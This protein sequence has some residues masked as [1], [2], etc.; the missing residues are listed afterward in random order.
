MKVNG[1]L[2]AAQLEQ[3]A[4]DPALQPTGRIYMNIATP[5]RAL[6]RI[7]DGTSWQQLQYASLE[8]VVSQNSGTSC[9]VDWSTGLV[10]KVVLSN[11]CVISFTNP[12][13]GKY[14]RLIVTQKTYASALPKATYQY[15]LNM[16]DQDPQRNSYQ[17]QS[18][19][20]YNESQVYTWYYTAGIRTGYATVPA[21]I[22]T[23]TSTIAALGTGID[24][25]PDRKNLVYGRAA[26]PF[27]ANHQLFD[28]GQRP[29]IG[30]INQVTPGA[31]AAQVLA[32]KYSPDGNVVFTV[33]G[34]TPFIQ[35]YTVDR[36]M[37]SAVAFFSNPVTLPTGAGASLDVHPSGNHVIVGHATTPFMSAYPFDDAGFG[38]KISN[39]VTLPAN[40]VNAVAFAP[41]GDYVAT[42]CASSPFIQ[43]WPFDPV[44]SAIGTVI[45]NPATLPTTGVAATVGKGIAWRPQGDYIA[46]IDGTNIYVTGFNRVSGAHTGIQLTAA[47]GAT[48]TCV[49]WSPDG[50]YLFVGTTTTPAMK[51]YDFSNSSLS[52]TVSFDGAAPAVQVNDIVIDQT[53]RMIICALNASPWIMCYPLPTKTRNYLRV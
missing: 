53:G 48:G 31:A 7:F 9:T 51:V 28:A 46:M 14:H 45:A 24:L 1:Q 12:Q 27:L 41:T 15:K 26:S 42:G 6:P 36:S 38:S 23:P 10:Q 17:P 21:A 4:L 29:F 18:A 39:P 13:A 8:T 37:A 35:S 40:T 44:T 11:H 50:Q 49:Q 34:T 25:S 19:L 3:I 52:T 16:T 5:A 30:I 2:E 47:L 43:V 32:I 22:S 33:G 20:Q